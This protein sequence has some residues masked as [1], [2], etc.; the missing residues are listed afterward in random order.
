MFPGRDGYT[1]RMRNDVSWVAVEIDSLALYGATM[2]HHL[3]PDEN[4]G[5][6]NIYVDVLDAMGKLVA[7]HS[8]WRLAWDWE[9]RQPGEIAPP[10]RFEKPPTEPVANIAIGNK[11]MR[12]SIWIE[13]DGKRVSDILHGFTTN[14]P[15]ER[16]GDGSIGNSWGHHSYYVVFAQKRSVPPN[17]DDKP[18]VDNGDKLPLERIVALETAVAELQGAMQL[19]KQ[20]AAQLEGE[21]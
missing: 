21:L 12:V 10:A 6:H 18:P 16:A 11:L 14:M 4:R 20:L 13:K 9:E 1:Y 7:A 2:I 15:D 3:T 8:S 17:G 19:I 5:K